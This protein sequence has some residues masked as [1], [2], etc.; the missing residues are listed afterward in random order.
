MQT[1]AG[2]YA[3]PELNG[4]PIQRFEMTALNAINT[5]P[6]PAAFPYQTEIIWFHAEGAAVQYQIAFEVP[7]SSLSFEKDAKSDHARMHVSVF[8]IVQDGSGQ[9]I[10]KIS[11]ELYRDVLTADV[12][13]IKDE[14]IEYAEPIELQTAVL[15]V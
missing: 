10:N 8:A 13:K 4:Q 12:G 11:R 7:V 5:R 3:L 14:K 1:R 2:Y 6:A 15:T 9:I